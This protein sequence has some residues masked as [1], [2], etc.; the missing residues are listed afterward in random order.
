[1]TDPD[2]QALV[3]RLKTGDGAA[4]KDVFSQHGPMLLGYATRM[5]NDRGLAE[6]VVQDA[7]ISAYRKIDTFDGRA[8]VKAWLARIVRNRAIDVLRR[9]NRLVEMPDGDPE[10]G[11]FD[12][13]GKWAIS[14]PRFPELGEQRLDDQRLL[15]RVRKAMDALP[16]TQ[17]DVLL[18][19]EVHGFSTKEICA[20][21]DLEPGNVRIRI[22]RARKALRAAVLQG[23]PGEAG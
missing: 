14:C 17:R 5:L 10:A 2:R 8:S 15:E 12:E 4:W 19:K 7:L 20:A 1:M 11:Y 22:H 23:V 3:E 18:L 6:D 13:R 21:L 9:R 16:H